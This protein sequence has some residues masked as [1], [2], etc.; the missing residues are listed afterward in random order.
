MKRTLR[1]SI[2]AI[3]AFAIILLVRLPA[4]WVGGFLPPGIVCTDISGTAW[5]GSCSGLVYNGAAVGNL[6]WELHPAALLHGKLAAFVDLT[7]GE[8]FLRGEIEAGRGGRYGAH[9]LQAQMPLDPPLVPERDIERAIRTVMLALLRTLDDER[10]RWI[11][12]PLHRSAQSE[13]ALTGIADGY[14]TNVIVDR[15][16]IDDTGTRWVIDFKTSRHEGANLEAFLA[17]EIKRYRSQLERNVAL[18]RG[19][20]PE[21]VKA[22]LYFPLMSRFREMEPQ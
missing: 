17:E 20:G 11:F 10:G 3:L 15:T 14:L 22:A 16:F 18:A 19:L 2:L 21:P 5:D 12:S 13:L 1:F 7:R 4:S 8:E 9:N 6:T